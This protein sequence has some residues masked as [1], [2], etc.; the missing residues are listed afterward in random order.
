LSR[1]DPNSLAALIRAT[2]PSLAESDEATA[3][4]ERIRTLEAAATAREAEMDKAMRALRQEHDKARTE[5]EKR[6]T[7][8]QSMP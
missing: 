7:K 4:R 6:L 2:K 3:L 8:Q 1:K 5:F